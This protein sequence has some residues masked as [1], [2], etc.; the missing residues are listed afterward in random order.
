MNADAETIRAAI[1]F[2]I[3]AIPW[4]VLG[5]DALNGFNI[6]PAS[7][8]AI[9]GVAIAAFLVILVGLPDKAFATRR[10]SKKT[11]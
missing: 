6:Q 4:I 2:P 10:N 5:S 1:A 3:G 8:L 7:A 11:P 9:S